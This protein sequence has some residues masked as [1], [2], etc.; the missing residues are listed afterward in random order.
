M[1]RREEFLRLHPDIKGEM[2]AYSS[3]GEKLGRVKSLN[4]DS[5][6]IEKGFFFP[7][8]LVIP[9]DNIVDVKGDEMIIDQRRAALSEWQGPERQDVG[10]SGSLG[11]TSGQLG[12]GEEIEIPLREEE[13]EAQKVEH[14][15]GEVHL[16][17]V[18][19]TEHRTIT[20]PVT[21]EEVVVEHTPAGTAA[22]TAGELEAGE[23]AFQEEEL[24]IPIME[25]EVE[26]V[27][28]MR[29]REA[30]HARKVAHTEQRELSGDVRVE[31][32]EV[33]KKEGLA[34]EKKEGI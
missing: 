33:E 7:R 15:K 20:V 25:E 4:Q 23:G 10:G 24:T 1:M 18:V 22:G 14:Q 8:D 29:I 16:R 13:L 3:D 30:I 31:D 19:R 11:M 32:L 26:L 21:T 34:Q 27:K 2:M 9:Y 5:I 17:K 6:D 28:H 12:R